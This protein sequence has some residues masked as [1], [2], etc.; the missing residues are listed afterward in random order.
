LYCLTASYEE[1][2]VKVGIPIIGCADYLKLMRGRA[3][4]NNL[5][6]RPPLFPDHL[7]DIVAKWDPVS[8]AYDSIEGNPFH[9]KR[10][11]VLSGGQ[12]LL[13]PFEPSREFF[14]KLNVGPTGVKKLVIE[15]EAVHEYTDSMASV[16]CHFIWKHSLKAGVKATF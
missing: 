14:E 5:E 9:G 6:F 10:I 16:L 1:P 8:T 15:P 3:A 13:V 4:S 12:D 2:R 7:F 11:L